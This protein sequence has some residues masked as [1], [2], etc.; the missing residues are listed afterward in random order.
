MISTTNH[1]RGE[2]LRQLR[3]SQGISVSNLARH[4]HLSTAQIL[5]L[6][7]G[8]VLPGK[9]SM[10]YSSA[11]EEIAAMKVANA[12]G[13]DP[14]SL[15]NNS[16]VAQLQTVTPESKPS[17]THENVDSFENIEKAVVLSHAA[18][19]VKTGNN[20]LMPV[21]GSAIVLLICGTFFY[22]QVDIPF[23][24][25]ASGAF[26]LSTQKE[27][28]QKANLPASLSPAS[29][30]TLETPEPFK[31]LPEVVQ[32]AATPP[33]A[34]LEETAFGGC[35][36]QK[37]AIT[38]TADQPQKAGV[39]VYVEALEEVSLCVEDSTGVQHTTTL[40]ANE[41]KTFR[42]SPPWSV[43]AS[44]TTKMRLFFQGQRLRWSEEKDAFFILKE[45]AG[46]F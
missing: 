45:T 21:L 35:D 44:D 17:T 40:K 9:R 32:T 42:G 28:T 43:H 39:S 22:S 2:Q 33:Q 7:Y 29:D 30:R 34:R 46:I 11:I 15:W 13:A 23:N 19:V 3:E 8:D 26:S 5:Q 6:E 16:V 18:P 31:A 4:V 41:H 38:L 1:I 14:Q 25:L 20:T 36:R 12:L 24:S 27:D 37:T 10:F